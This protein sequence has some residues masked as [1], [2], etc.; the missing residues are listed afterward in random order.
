MKKILLVIC[1]LVS[2]IGMTDE[3][4]TN[5]PTIEK[6]NTKTIKNVRIDLKRTLFL[7]GL[8]GRENQENIVKLIQKISELGSIKSD[9]PIY[10]IIDSPGGSVGL[11][12]MIV[13]AIEA[14]NAPVYTIC[15]TMCASMAAVIH[16]YGHRRYMF[17]RSVLMFHNATTEVKGD[18]N[19]IISLLN[20]IQ[21][22]LIRFDKDI[23]RKLNLSLEEFVFKYQNELWIHPEDVVN[24]DY[25]HGIIFINNLPLI[26]DKSEFTQDQR[27]KVQ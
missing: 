9:K 7:N 13:E 10:L 25:L 26:K 5:F 18:L 3:R 23:S 19:K 17:D 1:L 12:S 14:S 24:T 2:Q 6:T 27:L 21:K 4:R 11:G 20:S 8:I 22:M 16:S 15:H